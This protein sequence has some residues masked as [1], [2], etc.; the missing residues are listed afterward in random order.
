MAGSGSERGWDVP[1]AGRIAIPVAADRTP[2]VTTRAAV[3]IG[4]QA[5]LG[6][7]FVDAA[8]PARRG[9]RERALRT[10][11]DEAVAGGASPGD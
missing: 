8:S 4:H 1:A 2:D 5:G 3:A 6:L 7:E 11:C 9:E 10:R